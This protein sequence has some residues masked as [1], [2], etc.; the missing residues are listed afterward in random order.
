MDIV[1]RNVIYIYCRRCKCSS[2][3][4]HIWDPLIR[5]HQHKLHGGVKP[6]TITFGANVA[7][8]VGSNVPVKAYHQSVFHL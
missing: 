2:V 6:F 8:P 3:K 5:L 1:Y 4:C 7:S